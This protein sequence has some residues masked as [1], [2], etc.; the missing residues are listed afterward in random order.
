[1]HTIPSV[2]DRVVGWNTEDR[3]SQKR[4]VVW[5]GRLIPDGT[6]RSGRSS[7]K[8]VMHAA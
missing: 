2:I 6:C 5:W 7:K 3:W 1:M 4:V 8:Q